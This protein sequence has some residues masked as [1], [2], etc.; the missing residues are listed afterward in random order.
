MS[1]LITKPTTLTIK[2]S[3]DTRIKDSGLLV[4]N[5]CGFNSFDAAHKRLVEYRKSFEKSFFTI[6]YIEVG[7]YWE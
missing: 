5:E 1:G 6:Y 2:Y 7:S 4:R 3:V